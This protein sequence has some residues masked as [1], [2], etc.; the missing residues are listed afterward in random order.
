MRGELSYVQHPRGT[1]IAW[2]IFYLCLF[3]TL[4]ALFLIFAG[5]I[6]TYFMPTGAVQLTIPYKT[7]LVGEP[8]TF[9]LTNNY[10]SPIYVT[11]SCP[12]EPFAVYRKEGNT[13]VRIHSTTNPANCVNTD[14]QV[15]VAAGGQQSGSYAN[16]PDL[17]S[18]PGSYRVV[19]YVEYFAI[20][21]YQDFQV[22][23]K[24]VI[25]APVIRAP[26]VI[27]ITPQTTTT[28]IT[29]PATQPQYSEPDQ[30]VGT[31]GDD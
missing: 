25:P 3:A 5:R 2:G 11:N 13:W 6:R 4:I 7:Y 24:P 20:A 17:F 27:T 14:R 30:N 26:K 12:G 10:D 19:A 31:G 23:A 15:K 28:P 22:I 8:I 1:H 16:W 29:P 9:T 18:Q 21:P